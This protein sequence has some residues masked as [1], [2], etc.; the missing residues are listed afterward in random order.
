MWAHLPYLEIKP[1]K[2]GDGRKKNKKNN[3]LFQQNKQLTFENFQDFQTN[4]FHGR[5]DSFFP[6]FS[7]RPLN[8][9]C[10]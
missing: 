4:L 8:S 2:N 9:S 3:L 10:F 1:K 7:S 6:S 5:L